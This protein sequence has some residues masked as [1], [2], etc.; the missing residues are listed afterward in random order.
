ML[1]VTVADP[2]LIAIIGL[3]IAAGIGLPA[4]ANWLGRR[5]TDR[6]IGTINGS[7]TIVEMVEA[8]LERTDHICT[9]LDRL[10]RRLK[11]MELQAKSAKVQMANIEDR[12]VE[13]VCPRLAELIESGGHLDDEDGEV[14]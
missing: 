12:L 9:R 6:A 14:D 1:A 7:G 8:S 10:D 3:L 13:N 2:D 11:F 4:W 5:R